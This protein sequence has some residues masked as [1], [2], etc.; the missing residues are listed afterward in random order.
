MINIA[1]GLTVYPNVTEKNLNEELPFMATENILMYCVKKGGDRQ[2][3]HEKIRLHS[4][5]AA[6]RI[7]QDGG[8]NDL[9]A[10]IVADT[11]FNI[12]EKE[13]YDIVLAEQF[14]G[15]AADQT[16]EFL[17]EAQIILEVNKELLGMAVTITV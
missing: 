10:R 6:K 16:E 8:E 5:E 17:S 11:C 12:S 7:Q 14:T 1:G 13:I 3:L 9:I 4:L 2:L 15:R